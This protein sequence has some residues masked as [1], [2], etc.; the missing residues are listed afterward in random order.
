MSEKSGIGAC[1]CFEFNI[2][3]AEA[4]GPSANM[5]PITAIITMLESMHKIIFVP[6]F[7]LD[8]MT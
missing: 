2:L 5:D 3:R 1:H 4:F 7:C 6:L 8:V